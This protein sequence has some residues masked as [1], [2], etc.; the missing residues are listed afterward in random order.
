MRKMLRPAIASAPLLATP[1]AEADQEIVAQKIVAQSDQLLPPAI[2]FGCRKPG[3]GII[4]ALGQ[5]G[6]PV[7]GA[8]YEKADIG[9]ASRYLVEALQCPHPEFSNDEFRTFVTGLTARFPEAVLV[10]SDDTSLL[11]LSRMQRTENP[12]LR[13]A[14]PDFRVVEQCVEKDRTYQL[15]GKIGV[16]V[17]R[18]ATVR[19]LEEALAEA[20]ATGFPCLL[21]PAIG[22]R[23]YRMLGVKMYRVESAAALEELWSR[24]ADIDDDMLIQEYIPGGDDHGV[25]YNALF[26][27]GEPCVE[28]TAAKRRLSPRGIGFP[29]VVANDYVPEIIEPARKLLAALGYHGFANVEF[30][31]DA[32][33]GE[34]VL[35]EINARLNLSLLLSVISGV[36]FAV[37]LY[38][39]RL[40]KSIG[41][42]SQA[43]PYGRRLYYIDTWL[44]CREAL[45]D[46]RSGTF[47]VKEFLTPYFSR[48]VS[49]VFCFSD[50]LP[51]FKRMF[52]R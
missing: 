30:K 49:G 10:P 7:I 22:H 2:V 9:C 38:R 46:I 26:N 35:M 13:V 36:N 6:V 29:T 34:Y 28:I 50:P 25:N 51:F 4:R 47:S 8:Y 20:T 40:G 27:A 43:D 17:P 15:A 42:W 16:R 41:D 37:M 19:T 1:D 31:R 18:T 48:H 5:A 44:D 11:A 52:L 3:W 33:T 12:R 32:R 14:A 23:F 24:I 21:K 39:Q 45:R